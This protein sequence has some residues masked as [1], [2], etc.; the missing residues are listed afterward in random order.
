MRYG[1]YMMYLKGNV[2]HQMVMIMCEFSLISLFSYDE[3]LVFSCKGF[4]QNTQFFAT[5]DTICIGTI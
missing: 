3:T 1:S 4:T 5:F 2:S